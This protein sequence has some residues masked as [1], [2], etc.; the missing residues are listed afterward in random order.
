MYVS[1]HYAGLESEKKNSLLKQVI[2][3][4]DIYLYLSI[5]ISENIHN[6][7][8]CIVIFVRYRE[9]LELNEI[10]R[11]SLRPPGHHPLEFRGTVIWSNLDDVNG[12]E[13]AYGLGL[14]FV[15]ISDEDRHFLSD[16]ISAYHG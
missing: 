16:I 11:F 9:P 12:G 8:I 15:E 6:L 2:V 5:K 1:N 3:N 4:Y 7:R 13:T 10:Y 14:Y